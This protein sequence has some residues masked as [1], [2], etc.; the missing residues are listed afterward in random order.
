M[1]LVRRVLFV[2]W[3]DPKSRK[4]HPV[5]R[6]LD[7]VEGARWEFAYI[8]GAEVAA[9]AGFEPFHGFGGLSDVSRSTGLPPFFQ[10]RIMRRSR[11]DFAAYMQSLDLP[12]ALEDEIPI[13][14][15]SEGRRGGDTI[16]LYGLP[17]FDEGRSCYRFMFFARGVRYVNGAEERIAALQ[18]GDCLDLQGDPQNP[19]DQLAIQVHTG[20]Q[21]MIGFVPNTLLEDLHELRK[22]GS[23]PITKV[24]RINVDPAPAQLRLL[25]RL[26][27]PAV[28][29]YAPFSS[30]R[31]QPIAP[32]AT[33]LT[34]EPKSLVG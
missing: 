28:S 21:G 31:Y 27:V 6:L 7:H 32:S 15:R 13:L 9:Q 3:Q 23:T 24:E 18:R 26:E 5:A 34:I 10:N 8:H 22:R 11:P 12:V 4:I 29:G 19:A 30:E 1:N 2:A 14:A 25:C 33:S 17:T 20:P 16:E